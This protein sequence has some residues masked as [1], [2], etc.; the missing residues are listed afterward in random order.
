[1]DQVAAPDAP[2]A[3]GR[4]RPQGGRRSILPR[5]RRRLF[6]YTLPGMAGALLFLCFSLFP[7]LL[8]R[9]G[10]TQGLISGITAAFGYGAGVVAANVWDAFAGREG[11]PAS[12]R[13]WLIFLVVAV[14]AYV[15]ATVFGRYWQTRIRE[16]MDAP[17][18]SRLSLVVVPAVAAVVF[19]LLVALSRA[20]HRVYRRLAILLNRWIGARA[21]RAVGRCRQGFRLA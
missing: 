20:L 18:D 10:L 8:P 17:A 5:P 1:V 12:R 19:V 4:V 2:A 6:R 9:T 16:L 11:R 7:S 3:A 21:A 13:S 15:A 14:L